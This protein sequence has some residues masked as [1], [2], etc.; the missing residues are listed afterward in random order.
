MV[1][2]YD[3]TPRESD[4]IAVALLQHSLRWSALPTGAV[5]CTVRVR[6]I[7]PIV[8]GSA[9]SE[10]ERLLGDWTPCAGRYAWR[11]EVL[12]VFDPPIPARGQQGLWEWER[13]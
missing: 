6:D 4:A 5:L 9:P 10:T 3:L 11:L 7:E 13:P 2:S 12:Q 1:R 8:L